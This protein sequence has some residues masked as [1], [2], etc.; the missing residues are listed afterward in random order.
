[1][2]ALHLMLNVLLRNCFDNQVWFTNHLGVFE[3]DKCVTLCKCL[4]I[5]SE[6]SR[7]ASEVTLVTFAKAVRHKQYINVI[8]V[9][10]Q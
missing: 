1:M 6:F 3:E 10:Y 2:H 7:H 4:L 8:A 5:A 9:L